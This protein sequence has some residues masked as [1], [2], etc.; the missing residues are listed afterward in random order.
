MCRNL[1]SRA[2]A[3]WQ[4]VGNRNFTLTPGNAKRNRLWRLKNGILQGSV[5]APLLFNI[6]TPDRPTTVSRK[7]AY[8]DNLAIMHAA[9]DLQA[10][11]GVLSKENYKQIPPDL[12]AKAQHYKN[13]VGSLLPQ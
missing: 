7:H 11:D 12:E 4:M 9:G 10:V 5:L 3:T 8:A 1:S 6:Y 2:I 13:S